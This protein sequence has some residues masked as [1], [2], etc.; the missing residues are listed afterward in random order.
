[1]AHIHPPLGVRVAIGVN[2]F[3]STLFQVNTE[4]FRRKEWRQMLFPAAG[5]TNYQNYHRTSTFNPESPVHGVLS[6]KF[7]KSLLSNGLSERGCLQYQHIELQDA[8]Q[9]NWLPYHKICIFWKF[10]HLQV[11]MNSLL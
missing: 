3:R 6:L 4:N 11:L 1:M 10:I 5:K 8:S 2:D 7:P 9:T